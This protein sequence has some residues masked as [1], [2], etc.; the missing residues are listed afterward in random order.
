M[1]YGHFRLKFAYDVVAELRRRLSPSKLGYAQGPN[2]V[3]GLVLTFKRGC[4]TSYKVQKLG[5]KTVLG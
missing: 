2:D 1:G 3:V 5:L 4:T